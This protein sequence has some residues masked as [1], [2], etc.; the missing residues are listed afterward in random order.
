MRDV[1]GGLARVKGR[2]ERGCEVC[3]GVEDFCRL[4]HT[5]H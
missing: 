3:E 2:D 1:D 4:L 5:L